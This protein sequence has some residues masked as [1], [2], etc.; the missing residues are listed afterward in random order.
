MLIECGNTVVLP[1]WELQETK[2]T[3][4]SRIYY[5]KAG[6]VT[7]EA[8]GMQVNLK[9]GYL[10]ALPSTV[11]Y[12]VWRDK[13]LDFACTYMH[14]DFFQAHVT[15]LIE[16]E[17]RENTCLWHFMQAIKQGICEKRQDLLEDLANAM[18]AFFR[19]STHFHDTT[20]MLNTVQ[21][22]IMANITEPIGIEDLAGLFSYHPNYF[23]R[24]F[25]K[26]SGFTPHQFI[27]RLRMQY[28]VVQLNK[29]L[30][31]Q[32]VC[33]A[34]GFSDPSAF[35]R[36]FHNFYGVTPKKYIQGYRQI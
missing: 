18:S 21:N 26:E 3:G 19:S 22:Y 14:I 33:Y 17:V 32:E 36:A 13:R 9:P 4:F 27:L 25:R 20:E 11:P 5:V 31:N 2:P 15:G 23:I 29:G 28:A 35:T 10:Y 12:H 24:L 6:D 8:Q 34:C 1:D 30:S 16:M 7:F